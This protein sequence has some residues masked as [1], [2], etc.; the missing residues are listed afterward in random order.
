MASGANFLSS[1]SRKLTEIA[2]LRRRPCA[3][4]TLGIY[5]RLVECVSRCPQ[6]V[7]FVKR[8]GGREQC[9]EGTG[10]A[11]SLCPKLVYDSRSFWS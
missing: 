6:T 8:P 1:F 7:L 5:R 9:R 4:S 10:S 2:G 3:S 11:L